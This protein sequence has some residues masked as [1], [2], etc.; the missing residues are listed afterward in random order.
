MI[1]PGPMYNRYAE[2]RSQLPQETR[3]ASTF[4]APTNWLN[5][6]A[7][8]GQLREGSEDR[9]MIQGTRI[10]AEDIMLYNPK[11][12]N[13]SIFIKR[14]RQIA[15]IYGSGAVLRQLPLCMQGEA[16]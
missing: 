12:V 9:E 15:D 3:T 6:W 10:K 5:R 4:T 8:T 13:V 11:S 16:I 14:A 1:T 2:R 7:S